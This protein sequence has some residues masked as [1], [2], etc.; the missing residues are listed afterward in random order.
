MPRIL[1]ARRSSTE[2]LLALGAVVAA[3]PI[4]T[5]GAVGG[6]GDVDNSAAGGPVKDQSATSQCTGEAVA[7]ACMVA[8]GGGG[9]Y[10]SHRGLYAGGR[11]RERARRADPLADEGAMLADVVAHAVGSGIF[12]ADDRD[13]DDAGAAILSEINDENT[14]DEIEGQ[15]RV[16]AADVGAID[17]AVR[18]AAIV[19]TLRA[20]GAVPFA[21]AVDQAYMDLAQSSAPYAGASGAILGYHAQTIVGLVGGCFLVRGSWGPSFG[22]IPSRPGHVLFT[23]GALDAARSDVFDFFA[24]RKA[25]IL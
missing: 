5:V 18:F 20:G 6:A 23:L 19:A 2:A 7:G 24:F 22:N 21:M 3:L 9:R 8:S 14:L 16:D 12:P 15:V 13:D 10:P 4:P 25:P 1:A 11:A 17:D